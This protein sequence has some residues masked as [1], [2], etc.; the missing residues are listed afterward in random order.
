MQ[1]SGR[2]FGN[3]LGGQGDSPRGGPACELDFINGNVASIIMVL[4]YYQHY[5]GGGLAVLNASNV[6][7]Q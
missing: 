4:L 3:D 2:L 6:P 7:R 5:L 1:K